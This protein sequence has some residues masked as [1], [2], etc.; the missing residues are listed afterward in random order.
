[1]AF[2]VVTLCR[3]AAHIS[4]HRKLLFVLQIAFWAEKKKKTKKEER[5]SSDRSYTV[6]LQGPWKGK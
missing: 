6:T 4:A 3:T 1:M 2:P 5:H